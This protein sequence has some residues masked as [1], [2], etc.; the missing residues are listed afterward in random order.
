MYVCVYLL[1]FFFQMLS[2]NNEKYTHPTSFVLPFPH[3]PA[4]QA[5][6]L[7][8]PSKATMIT[9]E[10]PTTCHYECYAPTCEDCEKTCVPDINW[11]VC[12]YGRC[13]CKRSVSNNE[14]CN[15]DMKCHILPCFV[16]CIPLCRCKC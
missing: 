2:N 13:V 6:D 3:P 14:V 8:P 7:N 1:V 4:Y 15:C 16:L 12:H 11:E 5:V 9:D 10:P